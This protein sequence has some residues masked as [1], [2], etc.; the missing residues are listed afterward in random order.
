MSIYM[1]SWGM[2]ALGGLQMGALGQSLGVP[3]AL[4]LGGAC[5]RSCYSGRHNVDSPEGARWQGAGNLFLEHH[6][7]WL[8]GS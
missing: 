1:F 6:Y 8:K 2:T 3:F 4:G 5:S 7:H